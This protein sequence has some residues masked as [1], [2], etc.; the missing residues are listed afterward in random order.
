MGAVSSGGIGSVAPTL[1][2]VG[3]REVPVQ[4]NSPDIVAALPCKTIRIENRDHHQP[5]AGIQGRVLLEMIE[6]KP[7]Q[8]LPC[9]LVAVNDSKDEKGR[10]F[11]AQDFRRDRA[12]LYRGADDLRMGN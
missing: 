7:E 6:K 2:E 1:L 3:C 12:P 10:T 4:I 5:T 9:R 8:R 11:A